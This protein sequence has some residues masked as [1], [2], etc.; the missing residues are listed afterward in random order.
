MQKVPGVKV[1]ERMAGEIMSADKDKTEDFEFTI[2]LVSKDLDNMLHKD[3]N[4]TVQASGTAKCS[5]L[6]KKPL[7]V[8]GEVDLFRKDSGPD[9]QVGLWLMPYR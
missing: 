3:P 1:Q 8:K 2:V 4:H 9:S 6:S 7:T 5:M